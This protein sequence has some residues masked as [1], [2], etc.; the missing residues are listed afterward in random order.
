MPNMIHLL[1]G[2]PS[3]CFTRSFPILMSQG[4]SCHPPHPSC[5]FVLYVVR[6]CLCDFTTL[7][8]QDDLCSEFYTAVSRLQVFS[9]RNLD[10]CLYRGQASSGGDADAPHGIEVATYITWVSDNWFCWSKPVPGAFLHGLTETSRR[11]CIV[12]STGS[13]TG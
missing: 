2:L 8:V 10:L 5:R 11:H 6:H 3:G 12:H 7:P 4:I 1:L 13:T 9:F